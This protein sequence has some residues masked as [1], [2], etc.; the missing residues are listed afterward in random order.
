[1]SDGEE[2]KRPNANYQLSKANANPEEITY[3]YNR[4][5]RLAKAP[6]AVRDLYDEEKKPKQRFS[7]FRPLTGS[8]QHATMFYSIIV[9]CLLILAISFLGIVGDTFDLDGNRLTVQAIRYEETV[10]VA[11]RKTVRKGA[12]ALLSKPYNGAVNIAVAPAAKTGQQ[13]RDDIFF[14]RIFFTAEPQEFYR[15]ALPF[16]SEELVLVFQTEKKTLDVRVKPE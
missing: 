7:L 2:K 3:H 6:K 11:L 4:E 5:R 15:F 14:H 16:D 13:P 10:I 8:K 9:A 12:L 1:M